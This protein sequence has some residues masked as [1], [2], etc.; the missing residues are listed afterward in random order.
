M[1]KPVAVRRPAAERRGCQGSLCAALALGCLVGFALTLLNAGGPVSGLFAGRG[2]G[3]AA[4]AAAD[5]RIAAAEARVKIAHRERDAA[6]REATAA[7]AKRDSL[8]TALTAARA[9]ARDAERAAAR[10]ARAC[11]D[12]HSPWRPSD[13]RGDADPEL[14]AVLKRVASKEH[15]VLVAVSDANYARPGGMLEVWMAAVKRVGVTNALVVA[16]DDAAAENVRAA[17]FEAFRID[18]AIPEAQK[19]SGSNHAVSALKFRILARFLRLGYGVLLSDVDVVTLQN[20][21]EHLVRDSDVESMS[22]GCVDCLLA[23]AWGVGGV[24][25]WWWWWCVGVW[26]VCVCVWVGG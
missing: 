17:G 2:G 19:D 25:W 3:G 11:Q 26:C 5:E 9:D 13:E 7:R 22:D 12:R 10:A 6:A 4:A 24:W 1:L 16:L 23:V 20:P 21:F 15:E 14:A 8:E 18:A